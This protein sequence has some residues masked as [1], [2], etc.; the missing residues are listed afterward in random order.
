MS[1]DDFTTLKKVK[2]VLKIDVDEEDLF[3]S[4]EEYPLK[5]DFI[6]TIEEGLNLA[7][8]IHNE[9]ARSEFVIAPILFELKRLF[10][11]T[12]SL[13]SG[14]ELNVDEERGLNGRCDFILSK[15]HRQFQLSRPIITIVE[16]KNENIKSGVP[17]C[18][19]E[20]YGAKLYNQM[21]GVTL[22]SVYG[23][24]TTGASWRFL[25]MNGGPVFIDSQEYLVSKLP[26]IVGIFVYMVNNAG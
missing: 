1:Y 21:E 3:S 16:A 19:A 23:V 10:N 7:L 12:I 25:Q 8:A 11:R 22:E 6:T 24:V 14:I 4:V 5:S 2:E 26:K 17:Q 18:I 9:K 13:Y 20:M 15:T